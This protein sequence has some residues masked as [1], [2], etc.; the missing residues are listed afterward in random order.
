MNTPIYNLKGQI[1][2]YQT[3]LQP[4]NETI[5]VRPQ[6]VTDKINDAEAKE[7]CE[8]IYRNKLKRR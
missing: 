1:V 5:V 4:S 6:S 3:K 2:G 7:A 8:R